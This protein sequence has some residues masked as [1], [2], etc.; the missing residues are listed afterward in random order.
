M[1]EVYNCLKFT[2]ELGE[3]EENWL[4]TLDIKLR[5]ERKNVESY[6]FYEKPSTT[7]VMMQKRSSLD[8]NSKVKILSDDLERRL[9]HTD[10]R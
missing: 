6:R 5:V 10:E 3:G 2:T 7:N 4:P 1:Q 9:A 8:E